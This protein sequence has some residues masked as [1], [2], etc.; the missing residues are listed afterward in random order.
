MHRSRVRWNEATKKIERDREKSLS[1]FNKM[2][3]NTM[4][5]VNR[6]IDDRVVTTFVITQSLKKK[7]FYQKSNST[8][9]LNIVKIY[10]YI[11]QTKKKFKIGDTFKMTLEKV[12]SKKVRTSRR[13]KMTRRSSQ[14][15][16]KNSNSSSSS[17]LT[18]YYVK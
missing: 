1:F 2:S 12:T 4:T 3:Q 10:K 5:D 18:I 16:K 7:N 11:T 9:N 6:E 14:K 8:F 13:I 15:K 17:S